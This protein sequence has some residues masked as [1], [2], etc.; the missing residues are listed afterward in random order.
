VEVCPVDCIVLH[1]AVVETPEQLMEKY[2][3]ISDR[4]SVTEEQ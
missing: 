1:P 3:S 4:K 2:R